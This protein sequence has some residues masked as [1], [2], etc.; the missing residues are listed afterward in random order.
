MCLVN[1]KCIY[2]AFVSLSIHICIALGCEKVL[3]KIQ[4]ITRLP[5]DTS[6]PL[7]AAFG[8]VLIDQTI[9]ASYILCHYLI[10]INLLEH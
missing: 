6:T 8:S 3:I 7:R 1:G 9:W 10:F 4:N 5:F 2:D